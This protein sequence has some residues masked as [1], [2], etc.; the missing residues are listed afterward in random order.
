[1]GPR[2]RRLLGL[3]APP[4]PAAPA[5]DYKATWNDRGAKNAHDA[6]LTGATPER[7]EETGR[8][9]ADLLARHLRSGDVVLNIGCGVGRVEKYLAPQVRELWADRRQRR[10]D[11]PGRQ[12]PRGLDQRA[13]ARG[14]ATGS[15][16]R[17][18]RTAASTSSSPSSYCSTWSAKTPSS[19][20]GTPA[21]CSSP[22]GA[23]SPSSRISSPRSTRALSSAKPKRSYAAPAAC[24]LH[25]GRGASPSGDRRLRGR[26]GLARRTQ[27]PPRRDLRRRDAS[28]GR[29]S[30]PAVL[31][32]SSYL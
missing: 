13:P 23:S 27:R 26:G 5:A 16:C 28:P 15:F 12:A 7:F 10:D 18:S 2:I 24:A 9:D 11:P 32:S 31:P 19:T 20:C 25:R 6:I 4:P 3:P 8:R 29:L 14:R 17:L 21:G 30:G 22:A 1:M